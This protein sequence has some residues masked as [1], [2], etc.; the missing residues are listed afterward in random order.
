[1]PLPP[2][3]LEAIARADASVAAR[4]LDAKVPD[5]WTDTIPSR[6]RLAQ[7]T[8]DP[9]EQA[10]L[11]RAVV[12][13][14]PRRVVGNV[15]FHAP[16]DRDGRVEIG[17]LSVA[18]GKIALLHPLTPGTHTI[19]LDITG[20]SPPGTLLDIHNITTIIVKPGR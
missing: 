12:L 19:M 5:G 13:R 9:S 11:V 20:E 4:R 8:A 2:A 3:I 1:V 10:W 18:N 14:A 17:Y 6:E 15:G 7:L 16:P